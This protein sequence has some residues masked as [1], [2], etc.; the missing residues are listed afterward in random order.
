MKNLHNSSINVLSTL[1]ELYDQNGDKIDDQNKVPEIA[2]NDYENLYNSDPSEISAS[3]QTELLNKLDTKISHDTK[4]TL[5]S[6]LSLSE[7]KSALNK[8]AHGRTPGVDGFPAEFIKKFSTKLLPI[9]LKVA[10]YSFEVV[11]MSPSQQKA[12]IILVHKNGEKADITNW[13]PISLLCADY[14][15]I[16]KALA[17]RLQIALN[18]IIHSDQTFGIFGMSIM[19]SIWLVRDLIDYSNEVREPG[20][21]VSLDFEKAF[22]RVNHDFLFRTLDKFGFGPNFPNWIKTINSNSKSYI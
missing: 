7:L 12:I 11:T 3:A 21:L 8:M 15:I 18:Q 19:N 5:K 17:N 1:N 14:K 22:D 4:N 16:A 2:Q 20:I 6:E 10:K 13:R 9:L